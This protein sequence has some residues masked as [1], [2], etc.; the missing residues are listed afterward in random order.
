MLTMVEPYMILEDK[1][2]TH[3]DN[4]TSIDYDSS[5]PT[6]KELHQFLDAR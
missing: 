6:W 5:H 2:S 3:F 4:H 1:L